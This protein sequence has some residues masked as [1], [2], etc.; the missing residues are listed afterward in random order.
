MSQASGQFPDGGQFFHFLE[1]VFQFV[2][3]R[4]VGKKHEPALLIRQGRELEAKGQA[5]ARTWDNS[6]DT[7]FWCA[8]LPERDK[9]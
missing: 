5:C 2:D 6:A 4:D 3:L 9:F 8:L 1:L 7:F